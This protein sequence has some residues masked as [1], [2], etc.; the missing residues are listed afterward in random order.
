MGSHHSEPEPSVVH[1]VRA[2]ES[3]LIEKGLLSTFA[4]GTRTGDPM[5]R[6]CEGSE[7]CEFGESLARRVATLQGL[8][9]SVLKTVAEQQLISDRAKHVAFRDKDRVRR[10]H[11]GERALLTDRRLAIGPLGG[12]EQAAAFR[13]LDGDAAPNDAAVQ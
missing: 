1:R 6:V 9:E 3:L 4:S 11:F 10:D 13:P 7:A 5:M 8:P 2:L 12:I